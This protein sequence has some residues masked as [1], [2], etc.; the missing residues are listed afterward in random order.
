MTGPPPNSDDGPRL[1]RLE[2]ERLVVRP[3]TIDDTEAVRLTVEGVHAGWL[4]WAAASYEQLEALN[5]PPY[6][7]RGIE[8][9]QTGELIGMVGLVP[10]MGPFAQLPGF[11]GEVGDPGRFRPEVG[12]FW[13]LAPPHRGKGYATEAAQAV[14]GH[15]F[16]ALN[17]A[18]IVATTERDNAASIAVMRRLGMCVEENP[19][20][21]PHWFQVVGWLDW[22]S[23]T[24]GA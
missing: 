13:S 21:E 4:E 23:G 14:I 20:P 22:G 9:R 6:G 2:T 15:G 11:G 3:L 5:Q 18:R 19:L 7:E 16:G 12:M 1:P 24:A 8:L 10:S 17:L